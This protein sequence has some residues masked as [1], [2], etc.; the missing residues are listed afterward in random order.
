MGG[1]THANN[2]GPATEEWVL[3]IHKEQP[4]VTECSALDRKV[5]HG[6]CE[7]KQFGHFFRG[8]LDVSGRLC[9]ICIWSVLIIIVIRSAVFCIL[10]SFPAGRVYLQCLLRDTPLPAQPHSGYSQRRVDTQ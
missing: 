1:P 7:P 4:L 6:V 10:R 3:C 8:N 9:N 5:A 2:Q